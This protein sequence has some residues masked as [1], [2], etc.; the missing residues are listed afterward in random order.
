VH[1]I[2]RHHVYNR[3]PDTCYFDV[4]TWR[5]SGGQ[6]PVVSSSLVSLEATASNPSG[7]LFSASTYLSPLPPGCARFLETWE[8]SEGE[9]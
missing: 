6:G 8:A 2:W 3:K 9:K 7:M 1:Q 5:L 4:D